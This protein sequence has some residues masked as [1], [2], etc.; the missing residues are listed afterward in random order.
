MKRKTY[1][2]PNKIIDK[3]EREAIRRIEEAEN[4]GKVRTGTVARDIICMMTKLSFA[5]IQKMTPEEFQKAR[6]IAK[7]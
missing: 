3:I 1:L 4:A 6:E 2:F 7:K 5:Q